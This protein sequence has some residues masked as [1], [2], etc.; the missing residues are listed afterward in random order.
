MRAL[1]ES[2]LDVPIKVFLLI[3][4]RLLR[5]ALSRLF[6]KRPELL[7]VGESGQDK[8]HADKLPE[9][10]CDVLVADFFDT[11]WLHAPSIC[12][13]RNNGPF[14][15]ILIG[16]VDDGGPFLEA[17]RA[18]VNGYLLKDASGSDVVAAIRSVM[19][20]EAICPA[21]LC[22]TLFQLVVQLG[23]QSPGQPAQGKLDLTLRQRQLV[24]LVAKGLTNKEIA[25][26]LNLSEFTVRNHIHRILK[27]VDVGSRHE[28]VDAIRAQG[29][30]M[31]P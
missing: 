20:G 3:E 22:L 12:A 6:H 30:A 5:E 2:N 26:S 23:Q 11:A 24:T 9:S 28:A 17:V 10:S 21:K 27:Q 15:T 25:A 31:T 14:K 29:Y 19:R 13:D 18:G 1:L 7:V 16:M 8:G 4:N